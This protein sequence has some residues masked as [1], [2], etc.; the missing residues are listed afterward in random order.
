MVLNLKKR[1]NKRLYTLYSY[2]K[3]NIAAIDQM[4]IYMYIIHYL[5]INN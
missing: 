2:I 4:K 3:Y 1:K 5:L